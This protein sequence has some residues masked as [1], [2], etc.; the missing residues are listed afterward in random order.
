[1]N[2]LTMKE[3]I[4]RYHSDE[5]EATTKIEYKN[6]KLFLSHLSGRGLFQLRP[7]YKDGFTGDNGT[8]IF[9]RNKKG[10]IIGYSHSVERA[11][12]MIFKK[13]E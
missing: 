4:G 11:R 5:V 8:I 6:G 2:E 1:M 13:M 10:Q 3:Y 9:E 7:T 12:N